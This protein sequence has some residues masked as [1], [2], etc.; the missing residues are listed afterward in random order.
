MI[1]T[2]R[3]FERVLAGIEADPGPVMYT[4][5]NSEFRTAL[6]DR[7]LALQLPCISVLE[8]V[9]HALGGYLGVKSQ[10]QPGRQHALDA[11]YFERIEAINF[12]LG[13][14]DGQSAR[15]LR[16]ADVVLVGVSRTSKTPT[17]MYLANRGLKAANVPVVPGCPLPHE[18]LGLGQL[19]SAGPLVIGLTKDPTRLIQIRRNRVRM[20]DQEENT[21]YTD[22]ETVRAEL[23]AARRLFSQH[24]WPVID[25]T[26]RSIEETAAAIM[27]L[28]A[29]RR[30]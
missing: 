6:S 21:D 30:A 20:L 9:I 15:T 17:C 14:D 16:D 7:C 11:E 5:V 24:D 26:R 28:Y 27:G 23:A 25:V 8:P 12:A 13:H 19:E 10:D 3:Q 2:A 4:L 1:R 22:P 29:R 18:L